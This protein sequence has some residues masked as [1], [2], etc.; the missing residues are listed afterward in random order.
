MRINDICEC[1]NTLLDKERAIKGIANN[2]FFTSRKFI[3]K[4]M[5]AI[6]EFSIFIEFNN[7]GV[8]T[9]KHTRRAEVGQEDTVWQELEVEATAGFMGILINGKGVLSWDKFVTGEYNGIEG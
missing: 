2:T 7:K 3:E 1:A 6:K 8:F 9:L 5:G 4:K